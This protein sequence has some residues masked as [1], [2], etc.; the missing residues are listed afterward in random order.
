MST[1]INKVNHLPF[2]TRRQNFS[3]RSH[4]HT[5]HLATHMASHFPQ[6]LYTH[7]SSFIHTFIWEWGTDKPLLSLPIWLLLWKKGVKKA[8]YVWRRMG[9]RTI[10]MRKILALNFLTKRISVNRKQLFK[11]AGVTFW[12]SANNG[13]GVSPTFREI[14]FWTLP[15]PYDTILHHTSSLN[16]LALRNQTSR[17]VVSIR[18]I[19][20]QL[21]PYH[22]KNN[23]SS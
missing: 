1:G 12:W 22:T 7:A 13:K 18:K 9:R 4:P 14:E 15:S 19:K 8:V 11:A 5:A 17:E 6:S 20:S 21:P 16:Y 23:L 2:G 3:S 10:S